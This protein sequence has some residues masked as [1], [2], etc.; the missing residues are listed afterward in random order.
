MPNL[1]RKENTLL[2]ALVL[3]GGPDDGTFVVNDD[4]SLNV[5]VGLHSVESLF[6]FG[7]GML[8]IFLFKICV[9]K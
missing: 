8:D 5:F 9:I 2:F 6:D 3:E 1:I 4:N 7:H